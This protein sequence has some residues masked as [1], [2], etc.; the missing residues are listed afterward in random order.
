MGWTLRAYTPTGGP[1][2]S[3]TLIAE[4]TESSP[5]GIVGGFRWSRAPH[6]DCLQM[7]FAA[8]PKLVD[9][10]PRAIIHF[11][12][13]GQS[14]FYG[15][16]A[17]AWPANDGAARGYLVMGASQLLRYRVAWAAYTTTMDTGAI[18]RGLISQFSH[19]AIRYDPAHVPDTGYTL[20][21][22]KAP[23]VD[24][25]QVL[26]DLASATPGVSWGVDADGHIYFRAVS[27][28]TSVR[29]ED[30]IR[31]PLPIEA[32]EV[33]DEVILLAPKELGIGEFT[34]NTGA[35]YGSQRVFFV[36][37]ELITDEDYAISSTDEVYIASS[38]LCTTNRGAS[39]FSC[40][41]EQARAYMDD[42]NPNTGIRPDWSIVRRYSTPTR[43]PAAYLDAVVLDG[44]GLIAVAYLASG[45][46]EILSLGDSY[47]GWVSWPTRVQNGT[48]TRVTVQPN[49]CY[50]TN[51]SP[52][53]DYALYEVGFSH[54][55]VPAATRVAQALAR[56]PYLSPSQVE[57]DG[58]VPPA[59]ALVL[60][61]A[62]GG[63]VSGPVAEVEYEYSVERGLR[64][65]IRIGTTG[66]QADPAGHAIRIAA[67]L[68]DRGVEQGLRRYIGR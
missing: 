53:N 45:D 34:Y 17:R 54:W 58:Y 10:P 4:Y 5:G 60:L 15:F 65:L 46:S 11:L 25:H 7:E 49:Y 64:S 3:G 68:L 33:W 59:T 41:K 23:W 29:Y 22:L 30:G 36:G 26:T 20:S 44:C 48:V 61:G 9:I 40:T 1:H 19:P 27:T 52:S 56:A 63:D 16:V 42:H 55:D 21:S 6:G 62:P 18:T 67:S 57:V 47:Q 2:V 12:V 38:P 37:P 24:L 8:V 28:I 35:G 13:D 32:L 50:G 43:A 14:A 51:T 39:W 31:E 66:G